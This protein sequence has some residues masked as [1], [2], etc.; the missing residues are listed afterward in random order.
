MP[1]CWKKEKGVGQ[2]YENGKTRDNRHKLWLGRFRLK[3]GKVSS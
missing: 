2:I 3:F 1:E